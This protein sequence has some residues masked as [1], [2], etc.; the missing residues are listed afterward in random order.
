[1]QEIWK[2]IKNYEGL[3]EV[4]NFGR[5]RSL[6]KVV[7]KVNHGTMCN[8]VYKPQILAQRYHTAGYLLVNLNKG[9]KQTSLR[10][11]RL[12]AEAF[13]PNEHN[14]PFINHKNGIKDD[15]RLENLEW[16]TPQENII[17]A[18]QTGLIYHRGNSKP[19]AKMD[20]YNN[21]LEVFKNA[22]IAS[23]S[24]GKSIECS[25]NIRKVCEKGYGRC[26]NFYWKW[27]S[28]QDYETLKDGEMR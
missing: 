16:C 5:V 10:V 17:H 18:Y 3:Y 28:W 20:E 4:S 22:R 6:G 7:S 27:I 24:I 19:V 23:V 14:K 1:M 9:K 13:I 21:I 15:N 12:V 26:G 25:R 2:P 11:H 8:A